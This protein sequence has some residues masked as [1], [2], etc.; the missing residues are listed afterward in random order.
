[1]RGSPFN[2]R[3]FKLQLLGG[4]AA[5]ALLS[6]GVSLGAEPELA[7][8][9]VPAATAPVAAPAGLDLAACR[10]I[11]FEKQPNLAA[12]RTSLTAANARAEALE[13][14]HLA[15]LVQRDL[16]IRRKQ[17]AIGIEVAAA[18]LSQAEWD[19]RHDVTF[20]YLS[21]VYAQEQLA[22]ADQGIAD[23]M[24]QRELVTEIINDPMGRKDVSQRNID[25]IDGSLLVAKGRREEALEGVERALAGL[26]RG[27]GRRLR[28]RAHGRRRPVAAR[29]AGRG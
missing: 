14:L 13:H 17:S 4:C 6:V 19:T 8:A 12:A 5:P 23:L 16:P 22:V 18:T 7:P 26:R 24:S 10:Q 29:D 28:L 9:P 3:R 15:A 2:W 11:A 1:M 25:Q 27:D 21:A 20:T